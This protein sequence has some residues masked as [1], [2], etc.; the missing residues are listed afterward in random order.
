VA[1]VSGA[2]NAVATE[3]GSAYVTDSPEGKIL[4]VAPVAPH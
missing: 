3:E 1:T 4:V 2:R